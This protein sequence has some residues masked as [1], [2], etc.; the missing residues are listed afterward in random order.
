[1]NDARAIAGALKPAGFAPEIKRYVK[2][3]FNTTA[4]GRGGSAEFR[5][6]YELVEAPR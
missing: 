6:M 1:M 4:V 3:S 5:G 2:T